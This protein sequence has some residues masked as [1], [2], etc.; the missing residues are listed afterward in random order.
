MCIYVYITLQRECDLFNVHRIWALQLDLPTG[1]PDTMV[2][3]WD[4]YKPKNHNLTTLLHQG[5]LTPL[6]F[7]D[8][9]SP[10]FKI[11]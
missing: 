9:P 3:F 8:H 7:L 6:F 10:L 11:S 2:A 5:L 4:E 1:V